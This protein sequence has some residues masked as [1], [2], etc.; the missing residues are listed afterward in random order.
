M[1]CHAH[2][3][4]ALDEYME[5]EGFRLHLNS[6]VQALRNVTWLLQK[7]KSDLPNFG[8]WYP[9]WQTSVKDDPVMQWV[10]KARNRIVKEA[11]LELNSTARLVIALDWLHGG[12]KV[13]TVPPRWTARDIAQMMIRKGMPPNLEEGESSLTIERRW[14]DRLLPD[15]ELLTACANAL[16]ELTAVIK[17]AHDQFDI[18]QCDL[19]TR[20]R[21]CVGP[22]LEFPLDCM[23][24]G[25]NPRTAH[26]DYATLAPYESRRYVVRHDPELAKVARERYGDIAPLSGGLIERVP[27]IL[28]MGK[29]TLAADGF[30][31]T[32]VWLMRG[33]EVIDVQAPVF[34][35]QASKMMAMQSLATRAEMLN[36]DGFALLGE[37]WTAPAPT[38]EQ[39]RSGQR[40]RARDHPDRTEGIHAFGLTKDGDFLSMVAPFTRDG[41]K[42]I[43]GT[44]D[45]DTQPG[46]L[47]MMRPIMKLWGIEDPRPLERA[48]EMAAG[49]DEEVADGNDQVK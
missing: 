16:G 29:A 43:F 39:M 31:V 15:R 49:N 12:E 30:I 2:W 19:D 27:Q 36:A 17:T 37:V 8:E 7:Q 21:Q 18:A 26:F 46:V 14:V 48:M 9:K 38:A 24:L 45:V 25:E 28:E 40:V 35:D 33:E 4:A 34:V 44:S 5:P 3:H 10:V 1:D 11:D 32:T 20:S 42:V 41:K 23:W 47:M 6:L 13:F 22:D